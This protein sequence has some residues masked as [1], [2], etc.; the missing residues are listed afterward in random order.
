MDPIVDLHGFKADRIRAVRCDKCKN[1]LDIRSLAPLTKVPCPACGKPLYV[2]VRVGDYLLM[3][4]LGRGGMGSVYG[5][6]DTVLNRAVAIKFILPSL[7]Q[8]VPDWASLEAEARSAAS[9]NHPHV[10][11]V[12][13]FGYHLRQPFFVMELARG[14]QLDEFISAED[15]LDARFVFGIALQ[16]ADGLAQAAERNLLHSDIKPENIMIGSVGGAKLVDFGLAARWNRQRG[17]S[18][19]VWARRIRRAG[20]RLA[21]QGGHAAFDMYSLGA[22]STTP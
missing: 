1:R 21:P 14:R 22:T 9:L 15:P 2:P 16:V 19:V 18:R 13:T 3:R 17:A 6:W 11:Q 10:A 4:L 8:E 20:E 7:C 12:Y 5:A